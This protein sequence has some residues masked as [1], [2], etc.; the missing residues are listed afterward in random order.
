M[1]VMLYK[2]CSRRPPEWYYSKV[3]RAVVLWQGVT[4]VT[5]FFRKAERIMQNQN[6]SEKSALKKAVEWFLVAAVLIVVGIFINATSTSCSTMSDGIQICTVVKPWGL[7]AATFMV[8][9]FAVAFICLVVGLVYL[10][11]HQQSQ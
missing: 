6:R 10:R 5:P 11:K 2:L 3:L 9:T 8:G 4:R 1:A 7:N